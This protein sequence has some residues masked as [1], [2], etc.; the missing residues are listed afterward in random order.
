VA[1]KQSQP[2]VPLQCARPHSWDDIARRILEFAGELR[3]M[4]RG[5][6]TAADL[7]R[8]NVGR[9]GSVPA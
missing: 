3:E 9:S 2:H 4:R 6:D 5:P 8:S 1:F 7:D